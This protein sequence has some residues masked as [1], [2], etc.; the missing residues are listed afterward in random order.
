MVLLFWRLRLFLVF[1]LVPLNLKQIKM[2]SSEIFHQDLCLDPKGSKTDPTGLDK[3][4]TG[5]N[6]V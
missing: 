1:I 4:P 2:I 6:A 5:L 3:D